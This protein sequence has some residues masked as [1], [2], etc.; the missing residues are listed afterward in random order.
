MILSYEIAKIKGSIVITG[1]ELDLALILRRVLQTE[2]DS[3][4]VLTVD[5]DD[6]SII[7]IRGASD[8]DLHDDET[9]DGYR[10]WINGWWV[11]RNSRE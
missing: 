7:T 4:A 10:R 2:F 6:H 9:A 5:T 11:G 3:I 1:L 8:E